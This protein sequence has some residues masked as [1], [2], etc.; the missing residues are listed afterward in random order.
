MITQKG[1]ALTLTDTLEIYE[2]I[3]EEDKELEG[4]LQLNDYDFL[5]K[6]FDK[7]VPYIAWSDDAILVQ[8]PHNSISFYFS[9]NKI[10]EEL[11]LIS[12]NVFWEQLEKEKRN[13]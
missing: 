4:L 6:V 2:T 7:K 10:T 13:E 12:A 11:E 5:L 1:W 9:R 3:E 8:L